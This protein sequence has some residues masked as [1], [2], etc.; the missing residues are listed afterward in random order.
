M[1]KSYLLA[2][3]GLVCF[4]IVSSHTHSEVAESLAVSYI[5][6]MRNIDP[7]T[8]EGVVQR[9]VFGVDDRK[10]MLSS[11]YPWSTIGYLWLGNGHCTAT[12][13]GRDLV[14]TNAHCVHDE[15]GRIL[16]PEEITFYPDHRQER[17]GISSGARQI[18][19]DNL[20]AARQFSNEREQYA[21]WAL[22]RLNVPLGDQFGWMSVVDTYVAGQVTLAGFSGDYNEGE[23]AGI[24]QGCAITEIHEDGIVVHDCDTTAGSSGS[25]LFQVRG[26]DYQ[27]VALNSAE[28]SNPMTGMRYSGS[29]EYSSDVAYNVAVKTDG[30]SDLLTR[31]RVQGAGGDDAYLTVCNYNDNVSS[32]ELA[33]EYV[34]QEL[35]LLQLPIGPWDCVEQQVSD[36][37]DTEV[38]V[39]DYYADDSSHNDEYLCVT[40]KGELQKSVSDS[41]AADVQRLP[42]ARVT[43]YS[44]QVN[45]HFQAAASEHEEENPVSTEVDLCNQTEGAIAAAYAWIVEDSPVSQGWVNLEMGQCSSISLPDNYMGD[46][47]A[48]GESVDAYYGRDVELCV[49]SVDSFELADA[50][51]LCS[52]ENQEF[53]NFSIMRVIPGQREVWNFR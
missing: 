30:F 12:L 50:D 36:S 38:L 31:M 15:D 4:F 25:A 5:P 21:D 53:V 32:V 10:D 46:F 1:R 16:A 13:V 2:S 42:F 9:S 3:M 51:E 6:P 45:L 33:I 22:I 47:A 49:D 43:A 8:Y 19:L 41:C 20:G 24:H 17:P 28:S 29:V 18:F 37:G 34:D 26:D 48:H 52:G 40:S 39:H 14:L 35:E 7:E 23:T 11:D 27:I 44:H